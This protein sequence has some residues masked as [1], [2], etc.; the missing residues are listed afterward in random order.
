MTPVKVTSNDFK[1]WNKLLDVYYK[2]LEPNNTLINHVF[3]CDSASPGVMST[4][5]VKYSPIK[6][7]WLLKGRKK[8]DNW[9]M[10]DHEQR[11][12]LLRVSMPQPLSK[13]GIK[14]IKQVEMY[15][16][17]RPLI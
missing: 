16:K 10:F 2:I 8:Q 13:V 9:T 7:Q 4:Q 15:T 5:R 17:W 1:D 11:Q 3:T 6:N 12:E 14:P